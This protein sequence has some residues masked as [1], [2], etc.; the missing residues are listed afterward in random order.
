MSLLYMLYAE[1]S[2]TLQNNDF[3]L[4][5][6]YLDTACPSARCLNICSVNYLAPKQ[7]KTPTVKKVIRQTYFSGTRKMSVIL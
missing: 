4:H 6:N 5:K 3:L 1:R 2:V 7:K